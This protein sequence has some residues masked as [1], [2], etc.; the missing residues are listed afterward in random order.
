MTT[1]LSSGEMTVGEKLN[2]SKAVNYNSPLNYP[3]KNE[4][5]AETD[6]N[7]YKYIGNCRSKKIILPG[8]SNLPRDRR[9]THHHTRGHDFSSVR[10]RD[11]SRRILN[12]FLRLITVVY[13]TPFFRERHLFFC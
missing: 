7:R 8:E 9:G 11:E 10:H 13:K 2:P 6:I 4:N 5:V 3:R 1:T 12:N